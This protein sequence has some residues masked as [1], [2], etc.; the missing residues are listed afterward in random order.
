MTIQVLRQIQFGA[1]TALQSAFGIHLDAL[2]WLYMEG[3]STGNMSEALKVHVGEDAKGLSLNVVCR[4]K[5]AV[6]HAGWNERDFTNARYVYGR[7]DGT[8]NFCAAF[9]EVVP[10]TYTQR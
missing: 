2:P 10:A 5:S 6:G 9:S 8:M 4:T 3:V 1:V 7:V